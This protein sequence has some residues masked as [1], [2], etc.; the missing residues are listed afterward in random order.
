MSKKVTESMLKDLIMEVLT[1]A[2]KLP[3]SDPIQYTQLVKSN[4]PA[5]S[6]SAKA[7]KLLRNQYGFTLIPAA[8]IAQ[9]VYDGGPYP[10]HQ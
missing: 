4:M 6:T 5:I 9:H 7:A 10:T 3:T 2:E 8:Q 1:E